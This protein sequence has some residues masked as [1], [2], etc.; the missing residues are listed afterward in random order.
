MQMVR[1]GGRVAIDSTSR[2]VQAGT[3]D[4]IFARPQ[5]R[6]AA[7]GVKI[8]R[9]HEHGRARYQRLPRTRSRAVEIFELQGV[10]HE[11]DPT[12]GGRADGGG[13]N[14]EI[15]ALTRLTQELKAIVGHRA[16]GVHK[17]EKARVARSTST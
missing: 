1:D 2:L 14:R 11:G 6:K 12:Q 15:F 10:A 8:F 17:R 9:L 16:I 13:D 7:D 5:I 4:E 3:E